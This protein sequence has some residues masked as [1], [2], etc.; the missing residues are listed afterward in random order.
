VILELRR[1]RPEA[2][3]FEASLGYIARPCLNN[4]GEGT[5]GGDFSK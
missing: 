4:E 3:E 1:L 2:C 5:R